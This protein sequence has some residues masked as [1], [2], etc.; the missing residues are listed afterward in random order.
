MQEDKHARLR[1]LPFP[2]V[3]E[4]L[5]LNAEEFR[6]RKEGREWAGKCPI[7]RPKKNSTSFAYSSDGKF[8][9]FSCG[10][11]GRGAIDLTMAVRR[12]G[13]ADAVS[14]LERVRQPASQPIPPPSQQENE[15]STSPS[16]NPPFK[17]S[18]EKF[19]KT[20]A[21]LTDRGL[22]PETLERYG[23]GFYENPSRRSQFNGSVLLRISRYSDGECVGYLSRNIG[24]ATPEKPKYRF[25]TGL[26]KGLELFGAWQLKE[27]APIRVVYL[28]E[29]PFTV[30]TFHQK[31]LPAVSPF[32]WSV[33]EEQAGIISRVAKGVIALPDSDKWEQFA[34]CAG[35]LSRKVW[36][37][38]PKLPEGITDPESLGL[39][40]IKALA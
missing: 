15:Q 34:P 37:R 26:C 2:A 11:K 31:G 40:R 13:F 28:V 14:E 32:G 33:S 20:H 22:T 27:Q 5:G 39:E 24:E 3:I 29:S 25:P 17:S 36:V 30:M 1:E 19:F 23:V 16:E 8:Q 10:A 12:V 21:W 35:G 38:T 4:S 7:H 18:Y 6:T 9:C